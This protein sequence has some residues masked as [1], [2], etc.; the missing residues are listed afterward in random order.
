M[1][2]AIVFAP[3]CSTCISDHYTTIHARPSESCWLVNMPGLDKAQAFGCNALQYVINTCST[4]YL[5]PTDVARRCYG[6][7]RPLLD[8]GRH[9]K[10]HP[11]PPRKTQR[12]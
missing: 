2:C 7:R 8:P 11:E 3:P 5:Y 9:R 10:P 6:L 4:V 12:H 1:C